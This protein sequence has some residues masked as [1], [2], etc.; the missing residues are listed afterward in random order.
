M[1]K[2]IYFIIMSVFLPLLS[3]AQEI[4]F[5]AFADPQ[6]TWMSVD[7][8]LA[9]SAGIRAG[10]DIGFEMD[11]FFSQNYAFSSG[12]SINN[13][14]GKLKFN[15]PV[16]VQFSDFT[17]DAVSPGDVVIYRLQYLNLPLG[18]KFTT[19]EI[20]FTTFFVKLG[21]TAHFTT[22]SNADISALDIQRENLEDEI[23]PFTFSYHFGAG[24]H[25]SLGGRTAL[26]GGIEYK[27]RFVDITTTPDFNANLHSLAIR[28]GILF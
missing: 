27:H 24:V 28:L 5:S 20:G 11:Y 19:R 3:T 22:R 6:I 21:T 2:R 26:T 4:R 25:Y 9:E 10:F 7:N 14:G 12:L 15:E 18:M 17:V 8:G 23:E 1:I 16:A 13:L